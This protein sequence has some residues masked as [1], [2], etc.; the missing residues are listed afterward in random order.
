MEP[1]VLER[2]INVAS[3]FWEPDRLLLL[4]HGEHT[5]VVMIP[6][7]MEQIWRMICLSPN[8]TPGA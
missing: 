5:K 4:T 6:K 3:R 2:C 1:G 7:N 8:V